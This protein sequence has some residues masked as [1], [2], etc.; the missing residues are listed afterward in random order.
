MAAGEP[1]GG[2]EDGDEAGALL[3]REVEDDVE[4]TCQQHDRRTRTEEGELPWLLSKMYFWSG[5]T[6]IESMKFTAFNAT[7]FCTRIGGTGREG[8]DF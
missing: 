6:W 4:E 8:S 7:S 5:E 1:G 2:G 3:A